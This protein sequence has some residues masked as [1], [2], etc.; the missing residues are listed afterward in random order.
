MKL[1]VVATGT[2]RVKKEYTGNTKVIPVVHGDILRSYEAKQSVC[3]RNGTLFT[4]LL[5]VVQSLG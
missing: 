4:T 3:A 5:P 1:I 2:L